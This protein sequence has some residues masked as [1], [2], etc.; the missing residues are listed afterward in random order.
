MW[1]LYLTGIILKASSKL[2]LKALMHLGIVFLLSIVKIFAWFCIFMIGF[3]LPVHS[4]LVL[5][6]GYLL[7]NLVTSMIKK[8]IEILQ[9][10]ATEKKI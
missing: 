7:Y 5:I 1:C 3:G 10:M 6:F 2:E 9:K 4:W 8:N